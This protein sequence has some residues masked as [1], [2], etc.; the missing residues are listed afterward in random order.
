MSYDQYLIRQDRINLIFPDR[1]Q[2]AGCNCPTEN[3]LPYCDFHEQELSDKL[4]P[5]PL[6]KSENEQIRSIKGA[7]VYQHR[8]NDNGAIFYI[9]IGSE[10]GRAYKK[11]CRNKHWHHIVDKHG[12]TVEIIYHS[13]CMADACKIE[14]DLIAKYK[15]FSD[16]GTLVNSST[17]GDAAAFGCKQT[18]E[19]KKIRSDRFM[20]DNNPMYGKLRPDVVIYMAKF[21]EK[22]RLATVKSNK[23]TKSKPVIAISKN[24]D[25]TLYPSQREAARCLGVDQS[26]IW[27]IL[28][29]KAK[30]TGGFT[31]KTKN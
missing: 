15:R 18:P 21:K 1:C 9:G 7:I 4:Q 31:F 23:E 16:G 27:H 19:M 12:Y 14:I 11:A 17:G 3:G 30:T 8:R 22:K 5:K 29:G 13:L 2:M 24:G 28:Q 25:E 26:R 20:G 10:K 6:N